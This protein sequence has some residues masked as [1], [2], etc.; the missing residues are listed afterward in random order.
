[1]YIRRYAGRPGLYVPAV[2]EVVE[3]SQSAAG[4]FVRAAVTKVSRRPGDGV[5]ID[6]VW[7]EN[8]PPTLHTGGYRA[9]ERGH[10]NVARDGSGAALIRRIP[11]TSKPA[12]APGD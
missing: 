2:G 6:F 3:A 4:P 7:L 5:R 9:G 11:G 10:A 12:P 1:M 8:S